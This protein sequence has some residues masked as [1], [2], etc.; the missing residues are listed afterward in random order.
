[1]LMKS[2]RFRQS[3][4][5]WGKVKL[6]CNGLHQDAQGASSAW[7]RGGAKLAH[8]LSQNTRLCTT[9]GAFQ[10]LGMGRRSNEGLLSGSNIVLLKLCRYLSSLINQHVGE[11]QRRL[12]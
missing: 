7:V 3:G 4:A 11:L 8:C 6:M 10:V 5:L 9:G 1:M 2:G 12:G